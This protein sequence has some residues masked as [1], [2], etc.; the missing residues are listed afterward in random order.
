MCRIC[1]FI[2]A[3]VAIAPEQG[4]RPAPPGQKKAAGPVRTF[5]RFQAPAAAALEKIR[6]PMVG[7]RQDPGPLPLPVARRELVLGQAQDSRLALG[8]HRAQGWP[9]A[10]AWPEPEAQGVPEE[11]PGP[12]ESPWQ[13]PELFL[14]GEAQGR[15]RVCWNKDISLLPRGQCRPRRPVD[16][17]GR[18]GCSQ[19]QGGLP[20][21]C[22]RGF[23][24]PGCWEY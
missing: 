10:L 22:R 12:V 3:K 21:C 6:N 23:P 20:P 11:T 4:K 17:S 2:F 14:Q 18:R 5:V 16:F 7:S 9:R 15:G 19:T 8:W 13:V 1:K 24:W